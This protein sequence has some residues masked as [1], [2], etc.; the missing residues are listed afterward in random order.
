MQN[1]LIRKDE[2]IK[3]VLEM[4]TSI[5]ES[6]KLLAE[7][8]KEED[9]VLPTWYEIIEEIKWWKQSPGKKNEK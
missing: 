8:E 3:T 4:Q 9:K 2:I 1:E 6:T 7:D 5:L